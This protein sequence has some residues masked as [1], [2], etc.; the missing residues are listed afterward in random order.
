VRKRLLPVACLLAAALPLATAAPAVAAK[1]PA[2]AHQTS[3]AGDVAGAFAAKLATTGATYLINHLKTGALGDTGKSIGNFLGSV[4]LA[5]PSPAQILGEIQGLRQQVDALNTQVNGLSSQLDQLGA[6]VASG[7]YSTNVALANHIRGAVMTGTQ[8][9]ARIAAATPADRKE[10]AD[11]FVDFY[12]RNLKDKELTFELYLTGGAPGADG[13][14]KLAAKRARSAAQPFFT[15]QM[16]EFAR[17]VWKDYAMVQGE[18]LTL[19]LN[20]LHYRKVRGERIAEAITAMSDALNREW[21]GVPSSSVFPNTVIDTRTSLMW[22][23]RIDASACRSFDEKGDW[24]GFNRCAYDHGQSASK[25]PYAGA[26]G[27]LHMDSTNGSPPGGWKRPSVAELQALRTGTTGS[28]PAWLHSRGGFPA[29]ISDVW[30]QPQAGTFAPV[31]TMTTGAASNQPVTN[32]YYTMLVGQIVPE[33]Y[34]L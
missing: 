2:R 20:V 33:W 3:I 12:D 13:I 21:A 7:T 10:L 6:A 26:P 5:D 22:S 18:W 19:H 14:I 32:A 34:G 15:T 27:Y 24:R 31:V 29:A 8:K 30:A 9:L 17:D 23:W 4:G 25:A 1:R 11:D 28:G 16:S